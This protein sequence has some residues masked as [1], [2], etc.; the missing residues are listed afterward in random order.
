MV[1]PNNAKLRKEIPDEAHQTKYTVHPCNTKMYQG[2][3]K[4]FWRASMKRSVVEY[5]T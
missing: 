5:V 4:F 2:L 1:V 3:K